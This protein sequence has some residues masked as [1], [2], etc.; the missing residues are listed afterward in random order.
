LYCFQKGSATSAVGGK[1][2]ALW[3]TGFAVGK[4]ISQFFSD[5]TTCLIL[6]TLL[7]SICF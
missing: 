1:R 5:V 2:L 4:C 7:N 6:D 3:I